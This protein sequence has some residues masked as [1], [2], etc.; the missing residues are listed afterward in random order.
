MVH[1]LD[2]VHWFHDLD[3]PDEAVTIG[4]HF[5]AKD[6][7]ETPDT[8]Q[9]LLRYPDHELQVYFDIVIR[10]VLTCAGLAEASSRK[11]YTKIVRNRP[12][13]ACL[14]RV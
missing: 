14:Q 12:A 10:S 1:W 3:H 7:W 13:P 8:M 2:V 5:L 4:D 6:R 11:N 9:T